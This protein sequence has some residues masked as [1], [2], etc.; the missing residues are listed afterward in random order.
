MTVVAKGKGSGFLAQPQALDAFLD[1]VFA[2]TR[3]KISVKTRLGK[4]QTDEFPCLM[5]IFN[6]YP[7]HELIIHPRLQTDYYKNAP[8]LARFEAALSSLRAPVGYNG[9]L[10]LSLIHIYRGLW[11]RAAGGLRNRADGRRGSRGP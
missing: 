9:D 6:R 8:H 2:S 3:A 5:E 4:S 11:G 10:F 1:Q 7:I